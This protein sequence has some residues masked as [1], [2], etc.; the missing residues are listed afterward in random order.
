MEPITE[1]IRVFETLFP[2]LHKCPF[3]VR[4]RNLSDFPIWLR[5]AA[6]LYTLDSNTSEHLTITLIR[7]KEDLAFDQLLNVYRQVSAKI[8]L[9]TLLIA[10]NLN[11]KFRPLLVKFRIPFVFK[12]QSIYAPELALVFKSLKSFGKEPSPKSSPIRGTIHPL[13]V[14]LVAAYLTNQIENEITLRELHRILL[15]RGA[16]VST[17]KLSLVLNDLVQANILESVGKGPRKSFHFGDSKNIWRTLASTQ[18]SP[19]MRVLHG[20]YLPLDKRNYVLA[21]ESALA[22]LSSLNEPKTMTIATTPSIYREMRSNS[23]AHD[24]IS[25]PGVYIQV[26]KEDPRLFSLVSKINPI[27]LYLSMRGDPDERIQIALQ[28]MLS[29]Y[30]LPLIEDQL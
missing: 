30:R 11:P 27:E 24:D 25:G 19:F 20:H 17:A 22:K 6:D 8:G 14:K 3:L 12:D 18:I 29:K 9:R 13:S 5:S 10:D 28:E 15:Q 23:I 1:T 16:I 4:H 7:P 2:G 26:W 21:G